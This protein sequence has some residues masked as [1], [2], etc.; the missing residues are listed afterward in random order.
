MQTNYAN[1]NADLTLWI[2]EKDEWREGLLR[3]WMVESLITAKSEVKKLMSAICKDVLN[4][5]SRNDDNCPILLEKMALNI[6]SHYMP[7][8]KSKNSAVY[9][10]ATINGGICGELT[11]M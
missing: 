3:D 1:H 2:Y 6:F 7:M 9:L 11:N 8:K 5:M 4:E 10:Y